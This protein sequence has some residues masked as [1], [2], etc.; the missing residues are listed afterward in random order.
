MSNKGS[1]WFFRLV[2]VGYAYKTK[3]F[4]AMINKLFLLVIID[5]KLSIVILCTFAHVEYLLMLKNISATVPLI[6]MISDAPEWATLVMLNYFLCL[7][8]L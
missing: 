2:N 7:L 3:F 5:T 4:R 6:A 8:S 1:I